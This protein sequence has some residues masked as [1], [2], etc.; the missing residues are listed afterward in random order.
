VVLIAADDLESLE[1]TVELLGDPEAQ[2]RLAV[3]EAEIAAGHGVDEQQLAE[4]MRRPAA[5]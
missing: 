5:R 3:A 4:A 2:Q 1:A